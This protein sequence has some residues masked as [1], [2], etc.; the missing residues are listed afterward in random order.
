MESKSNQY[1]G[2]SLKQML[3]KLAEMYDRED[4]IIKEVRK[5]KLEY[6][7]LQEDKDMLQTMYMYV[8]NRINSGR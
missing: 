8:S 6:E 4:L 1:S 5:L 2:L 3:D 7:R